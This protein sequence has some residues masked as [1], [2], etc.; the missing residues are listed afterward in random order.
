MT[1]AIHGNFLGLSVV[2]RTAELPHSKYSEDYSAAN[3]QIHARLKI[4]KNI[5][6]CV[7]FFVAS[8]NS[9]ENQRTGK[10]L[11]FEQERGTNPAVQ[12]NERMESGF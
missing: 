12:K 3:M 8:A 6:P 10:R 9:R 4:Y 2:F 1:F 5:L 11:L 7:D